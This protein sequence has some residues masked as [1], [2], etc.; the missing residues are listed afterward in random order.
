MS[1][2]ASDG[3]PPATTLRHTSPCQIASSEGGPCK[4]LIAPRPAGFPAVRFCCA[5]CVDRLFVRSPPTPDGAGPFSRQLTGP[6]FRGP[7]NSH[8]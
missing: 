4:A 8:A 1:D 5:I 7:T 3:A 2:G 6:I